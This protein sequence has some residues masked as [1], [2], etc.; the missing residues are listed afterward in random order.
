MKNESIWVEG[1][2]D[3]NYPKLDSDILVD[4]LIIG[5]GMTGISTAYHLRNSN[6][7]VCLVE[8]RQMAMGVSSKTTGKLTFLQDLIYTKLYNKYSFDIAKK[9]Y[10]SQKD[11][12]KL[13]EKIINDNNIECDYKK[14][15]SYL[16]ASNKEDIAKV[17]HE[18]DLLQKMKVKVYE[19]ADIPHY[20]LN[21]Y[22][23]SVLD[24]AYFHP[25][26]YLTELT[27][28]CVR[29][30]IKVYENTRILKINKENN[31]YVCLTDKNKITA[32][33]VVLACHY[34]FFM[35]PFLFPLKGHL[36][37]SYIGASL[38]QD[39]KDI[40]G[41]NTSKSTIS[42]RY[43]NDQNKKYL[44]YLNGSHNLAFK[45]NVKD[46]FNK[47]LKDLN[48]INLIPSYIW[49]NVD[50]ITNDYLPYI[51]YID[52]NLLIGTGYN[53]WG[54]TNGS[55]AGKII[56]DLLLNKNN[57]Y[58]ELFNP[59]RSMPISNLFSTTYDVFSSAK[60][61]VENKLIKNKSFYSDRVL[62]IKKDGVDL[63]IYIDENNKEHIVYNRCP[64]LKCSLI[65]NEVELTWDC[66]CHSSRFDIDGK[67]LKGPSTYDIG[68]KNN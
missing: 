50:I 20:L 28:I 49:S 61:F 39:N 29:D 26:K 10:N 13:V 2:G 22:S 47:L 68:Y 25:V 48:K 24:T 17:V 58:R 40:S 36:E 62:F 34:P 57:K 33:K 43:H 3:G 59:E 37:R 15:E 35:L 31:Q 56:S 14:V 51:G 46:N 60:P 9:Y 18:K 65:F 41:I 55:L 6:L 30:G 63:A 19:H 27:K 12:I 44:L 11:A 53:T 7:K 66:P 1:F 5:G 45:Y 4:I 21:Y 23:I 52:D 42:F 64:H 67:C 16:F 8:G 32:K 54:M 38:V